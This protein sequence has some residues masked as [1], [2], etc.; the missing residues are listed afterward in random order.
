MFV[1]GILTREAGIGEQVAELDR[2]QIDARLQLE[3]RRAQSIGMA[4]LGQQRFAGC[5][6]DAYRSGREPV[7][8]RGTR[9][10]DMKVGR[11]IAIRIDLQR[12]EWFDDVFQRRAGRALERADEKSDVAR[13]SFDVFVSRY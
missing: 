7:Q 1:N 2:A 11:E 9:R 5:H 6:N 12:R 13:E 4:Q 8:R 3:R 10:R